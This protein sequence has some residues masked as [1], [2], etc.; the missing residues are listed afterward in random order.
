MI[1]DTR[2]IIEYI[3]KYNAC[4][5]DEVEEMNHPVK[6]TEQSTV[7][8]PIKVDP[9]VDKQIGEIKQSVIEE[10]NKRNEEK[11]K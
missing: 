4:I 1:V 11:G 6:A 5:Y 3:L 10:L 9:E 7:E 2:Y 8:N